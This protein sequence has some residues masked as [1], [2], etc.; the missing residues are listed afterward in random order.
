MQV[1]AMLPPIVTIIISVNIPD[2]PLADD[3]QSR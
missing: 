1:Q 3:I 2:F